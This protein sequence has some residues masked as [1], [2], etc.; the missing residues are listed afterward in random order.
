MSAHSQP[1]PVPPVVGLPAIP[2]RSAPFQRSPFSG[3]IREAAPIALPGFTTAAGLPLPMVTT[4][5]YLHH[6]PGRGGELPLSR[7]GVLSP[8][9]TG[10]L[11]FYDGRMKTPR[12]SGS[13]PMALRLMRRHLPAHPGLQRVPHGSLPVRW[14]CRAGRMEAYWQCSEACDSLPPLSI[15][16]FVNPTNIAASLARPRTELQIDS[17]RCVGGRSHCSRPTGPTWD[18]Q[19]DSPHQRQCLQHHRPQ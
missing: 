16:T 9:A 11:S 2:E 6:L 3:S 12:L 4:N 10:Q 7:P 13:S 5:P 17:I 14:Q 1:V 19:R 8:R 18:F 15:N